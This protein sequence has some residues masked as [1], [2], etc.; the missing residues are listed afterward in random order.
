MVSSNFIYIIIQNT[1]F[2]AISHKISSRDLSLLPLS[3]VFS[4]SPI[5]KWFWKC[6]PSFQL[7]PRLEGYRMLRYISR[8]YFI[9]V[10][11]AG[12]CHCFHHYHLHYNGS[13]LGAA[14][15][16][17]GTISVSCTIDLIDLYISFHRPSG[18]HFSLDIN[19]ML[20]QSELF[21]IMLNS[22]T[23]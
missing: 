21:Q 10:Y 4:I 23:C 15:S 19:S 12:N 5:Q 17:L 6:F 3:L 18:D 14:F 13:K 2:L 7:S 22:T 8:Y 1:A 11:A 9:R 16:M 20:L